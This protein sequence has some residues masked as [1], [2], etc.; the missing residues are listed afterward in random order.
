MKYPLGEIVMS[1]QKLSPEQVNTALKKLPNWK[2]EKSKL[3][4]SFQFK[5]FVEAFGFMTQV[6][7]YAEKMNHHPEWSNV[8]KTVSINLTTH[9]AGGITDLDIQLA[10]KIS[11]LRSLYGES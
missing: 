9:D 6:A 3:Q 11:E 4:T 7:L 10:E 2:L 8:Y 5:N 1:K